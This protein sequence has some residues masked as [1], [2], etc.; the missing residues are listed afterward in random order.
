MMPRAFTPSNIDAY[1]KCAKP[2][3]FSYYKAF[4]RTADSPALSF[5]IA[6]HAALASFMKGQPQLDAEVGSGQRQHCAEEQT[7]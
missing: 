4:C 5:G 7:P 2:Y 6:I 3:D 1:A